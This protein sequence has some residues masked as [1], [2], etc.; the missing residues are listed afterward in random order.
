MKKK[1]FNCLLFLLLLIPVITDAASINGVSFTQG[2]T[3]VAG[4]EFETT[5]KISLNGISKTDKIAIYGVGFTLEFDKNVIKPVETDTTDFNDYYVDKSSYWDI[6]SI[7]YGVEGITDNLTVSSDNICEDIG[8]Y[9]CSGTYETKW[10]FTG[11]KNANTTTKINIKKITIYAVDYSDEEN[12][13]N[14]TLEYG[15]TFTSEVKIEKSSSSVSSS[16]VTSSIK[17]STSKSVKK[18]ST[19]AKKSTKTTSTKSTS[20]KTTTKVTKKSSN[21]YLKSLSIKGYEIKFNKDKYKYEIKVDEKVNSLDISY[22][23][24]DK[25][26]KV[27]VVGADNLSEYGDKVTLTVTAEDLT[28][29]EYTIFVDKKVDKIKEK[30]SITKIY[31]NIKNKIFSSKKN[32][33]IALV[34]IGNIFLIFILMLIVSKSSNRKIDKYLDRM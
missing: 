1:I 14:L 29:K 25:K 19:T 33:T 17:K 10:Y 32:K 22:K 3:A 13:K 26:S 4:D 27:E 20:T 2:V 5:L 23:V 24:E 11:I 18:A 12:I 28:K 30:F 15:K 34:I 21:T 8:M 7:V 16:S 9:Y 6:S 31:K